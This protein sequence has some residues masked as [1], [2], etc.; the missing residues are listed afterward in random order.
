VICH[1]TLCVLSKISLSS[2]S[3]ILSSLGNSDF[4]FLEETGDDFL[5]ERFE[6][7]KLLLS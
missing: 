4:F 5:D 7:L 3:L 2:G 6:D 1:S